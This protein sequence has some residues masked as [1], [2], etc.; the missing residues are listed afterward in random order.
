MF[1]GF[2]REGAGHVT[3]HYGVRW[4]GAACEG[5]VMVLYIVSSIY[6]YMYVYIYVHTCIY[7][8]ESL[9]FAAETILSISI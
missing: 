3:R 6:I 9:E 1:R 5:E 7:V 8:N 2:E 4:R